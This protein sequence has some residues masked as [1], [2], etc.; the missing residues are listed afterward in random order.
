MDAIEQAVSKECIRLGRMARRFG[1]DE[2]IARAA[3]EIAKLRFCLSELR[4]I[5]AKGLPEERSKP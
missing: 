3:T 5:A 1:C 2:A 4:R